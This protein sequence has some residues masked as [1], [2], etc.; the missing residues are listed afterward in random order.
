MKKTVLLGML[1]ATVAGCSDIP[2]DGL[3]RAGWDD[4]ISM[5]PMGYVGDTWVDARGCVYFSTASGWVPHV[6]GN[7]KQVCR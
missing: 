5:P 3:T 1:V 6:G 4:P 2:I 7:L